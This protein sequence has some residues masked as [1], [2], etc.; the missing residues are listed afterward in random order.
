APEL[1]L[2]VP[3]ALASVQPDE[4]ELPAAPPLALVKAIAVSDGEPRVEAAVSHD[5]ARLFVLLAFPNGSTSSKLTA[6]SASIVLAARFTKTTGHPPCPGARL[7][8]LP[9]QS[10]R[11]IAQRFSSIPV[12]EPEAATSRW[13]SRTAP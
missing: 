7:R 3:R 13:L 5:R 1:R 10:N 12:P 2:V 9:F 11:S 6:G 4:P 8:P